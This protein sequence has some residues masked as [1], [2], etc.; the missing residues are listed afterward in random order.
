VAT[1]NIPSTI[2]GGT[3]IIDSYS[4]TEKNDDFPN[5]KYSGKHFPNTVA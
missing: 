4:Q 1:L 3:I 2:T 5:W